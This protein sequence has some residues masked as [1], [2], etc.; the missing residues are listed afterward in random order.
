MNPRR[1]RKGFPNPR[2]SPTPGGWMDAPQLQEPSSEQKK[3]RRGQTL[4][5]SL[6]IFQ[7][8]ESSLA[9]DFKIK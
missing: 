9:K 7:L 4:N 8:E 6:G 2:P 3:P 1:V 5:Q